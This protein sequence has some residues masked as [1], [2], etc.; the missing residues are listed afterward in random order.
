M[1][2]VPII[3]DEDCSIAEAY[4]VY[5]E[6]EDWADRSLFIIDEEGIVRHCAMRDSVLPRRPEEV[7]RLIRSLQN[8]SAL[9]T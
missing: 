8:C 9:T 5:N 3:S 2:V 1:T 4:G 7:L 6:E